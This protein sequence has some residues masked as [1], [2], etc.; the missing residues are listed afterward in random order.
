[1]KKARTATLAGLLLGAALLLG[2]FLA[3]RVD[4]TGPMTQ[5]EIEERLTCQCGCGL[6]VHSCN[7]LQCGFGEPVKRDIAKSLAAGQTGEEILARYVAEYGEKI[8]SSPTHSGFNLVA[9]Y[10]PYVAVVL[11]AL[12]IVF[13]IRRW[14]TDGGG[15]GGGAGPTSGGP[16]LSEADRRRLQRELE[17]L[18][19]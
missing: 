10:G 2:T 1:M 5:S 4:A 16:T 17:D 6:T 13:V 15:R 7:H 9:W 8:L 18:E 3:N 11:G 19:R 12:A 14:S